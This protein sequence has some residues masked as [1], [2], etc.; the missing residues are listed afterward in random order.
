MWPGLVYETGANDVTAERS[1]DGMGRMTRLSWGHAANT[2]PQFDY[3]YDDSGNL[4]TKT[5]DHRSGDP[6]EKYD[7]DGLYR[8]TDARYDYRGVTHSFDY[9]PDV[10][11]DEDAIL[12]TGLHIPKTPLPRPD[13]TTRSMR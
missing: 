12:A 13:I 7:I 5:H 9:D 10:H 1:Y 3:D 8:L 4:L 11:R 6:V 2:L